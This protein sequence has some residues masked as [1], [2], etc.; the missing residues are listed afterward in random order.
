M[1]ILKLKNMKAKLNFITLLKL[2]KF[3]FTANNLNTGKDLGSKDNSPSTNKDKKYKEDISE[4][5]NRLGNDWKS[6][7]NQQEEARVG[8]EEYCEKEGKDL[9]SLNNKK[10]IKKDQI[11]DKK[12]KEVD[13]IPR[14]EDV[15][16]G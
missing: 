4:D 15:N 8:Q 13:E 3:Y 16:I 12:S 11:K 6:D 14:P 5:L 9:K 7:P 2:P 10:Y 1:N